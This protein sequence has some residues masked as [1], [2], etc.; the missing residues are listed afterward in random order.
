MTRC[1]AFYVHSTVR[2]F[3]V[4]YKKHDFKV[5]EI[6]LFNNIYVLLNIPR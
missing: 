3:Y 2:V 5:A 1:I 6:K 4:L